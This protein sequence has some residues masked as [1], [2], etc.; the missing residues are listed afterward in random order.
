[1]VDKGKDFYWDNPFE[2]QAEDFAKREGKK[3]LKMLNKKR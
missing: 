1:M 3:V 2:K